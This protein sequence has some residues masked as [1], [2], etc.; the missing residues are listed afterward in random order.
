MNNPPKGKQ[1]RPRKYKG[2]ERLLSSLGA[3][4][5]RPK[6]HQRVGVRRGSRGDTIWIKVQL[7]FGATWRGKLYPNG[8]SL[9]I[10]LGRRESVDWEYALA[11]R[12]E[13][14]RRADLN[15]PLE[16]DALPT[17]KEWSADWL[18]RKKVSIKR[19]D[20][21][22]VHLD[23][24]L[25]PEFGSYRLGE[26]TSANIERWLSSK[27]AES[28]SP[29]YLKRIVATLKAILSD[30]KRERILS[31]NPATMISPIKGIKARQ[32]FL[33][34]D[35]IRHLLSCAGKQEPWLR[36]MIV[37]AL[38]SGM[39]RGEIRQLTWADVKTVELGHQ[40]VFLGD[41]K[42]GK[43]RTITCTDGMIEV[44][45]NQTVYRNEEDNR[46]W[47]VS[48][49]TFKRR[50]ELCRREAGLSDIVFHDLRRTNATL[51][52]ASGVNLRTLASRMGHSD[53][54]MLEKHYAMIVGS[55]EHD[56]AKKIQAVFGGLRSATLTN[57]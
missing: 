4:M 22:K 29:S 39:R 20:T 35:E 16:D 23:R 45:K 40:V 15:Q 21:A 8:H 1:G 5:R 31:E 53:L 30:A 11:R 13:F 50:W 51:S 26:I 6:Y 57:G 41:S 2:F 14:Q 9:E 12:D 54:S 33:D 55:A 42:S 56:A 34:M 49:T 48:D 43:A 32:R 24:H 44:L 37:W 46:L 3:D 38:H 36:N 28:L 27:L 18:A 52:A 10:K 17:F 19:P 47:P 7:P 25:V